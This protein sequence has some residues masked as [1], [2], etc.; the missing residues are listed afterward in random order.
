MTVSCLDVDDEES[1]AAICVA[2]LVT[3]QCTSVTQ[4]RFL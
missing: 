4:R 1:K 2:V 3:L